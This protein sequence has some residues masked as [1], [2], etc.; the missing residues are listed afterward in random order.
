MSGARIDREDRMKKILLGTTALV[1]AGAFVGA[2]QADE[3][4]AEP[5][6]VGVAGYATAVVGFVSDGDDATRGQEVNHVYEIAVSGSTTLDN[7]ITVAVHGQLGTSG[8]YTD[9]EGSRPFDETH[10]TMS[11]SFGS[12]RIGRTES[13]AFNS[14]V[15]APGY[16][17]GGMIGVNYVW[18]NT[19]GA[20]VNTYHSG[21]L[22]NEDAMK[23]VYTTPNFNGLTIGASY[24]PNNSDASFTGRSTDGMGEHTAVGMTYSTGFMDGGSLTLGTGYETASNG[25]GGDDASA[26]RAG[27]NISVDQISFGGSMYDH[28][29][30]G[31]QY[32]VGASWTEGATELGL[33]YG[34][35]ED[36][37]AGLTLAHLTYTLG[38]GVLI[39][40]QIGSSEDVTQV[41]L[42]TSVFF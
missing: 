19:A 18:F 29:A 10:I 1:A 23:L 5:V 42:G 36:G 7:G 4:M 22:G 39:G 27:L 2:A 21:A 28:D 14:T 3:M 35:N 12:L 17:I 24:A 16:G 25:G 30:D 40:G 11:G 38:P 8:Q 41:M 31:M 20:H 9:S 32:D 6:S 37:D 15:A 26:M 13:A 33:Q 34:H